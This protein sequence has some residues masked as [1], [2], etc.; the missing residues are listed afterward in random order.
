MASSKAATVEAYLA[1][2]PPERREAMAALRDVILEHLPEGFEETMQYGMI[3]Y[4]V[5]FSRYPKTYN[6]QPL[7]YVALAS[8]KHYMA[9][10]F[11]DFYDDPTG[12]QRLREEFEAAGKRFDMGKSCLRFRRLSDLP[13]DVIGRI[14][15]GPRIPLRRPASRREQA[16]ATASAATRCRR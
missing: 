9:F 16:A 6:K 2:L 1:E 15:G 12:K 14:T 4:V 5:P 3:T 11:K 7:G 13:L 8:Q 10:Y